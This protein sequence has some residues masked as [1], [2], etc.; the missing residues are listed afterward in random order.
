MF[1]KLFTRPGII[2]RYRAAP[3]YTERLRYLVHCAQ[4]GA[5]QRTLRVIAAHQANVVHF[6]DLRQGERVSQTRIEAAAARWSLPGERRCSQPARAD[7]SQRFLGHTVRWLRFADMLEEPDATGLA[8]VGELAA[9][10]AWMCKERGWSEDTVLGCCRTVNCFFEWL[11]EWGVAL[12]SVKIADIDRAIA[13]WHGRNCSRVTIHDYA[14]RLRTFFRFAEHRGWCVA[15]L[16]DGIMPSRFHPG[17]T[18]PK[19]LTRHEVMRLLATTESARPVDVRDRAI[20]MLLTVY[21]LRSGEVAGLRLDDLDWEE[22]TL[23]VRC[24]KPGRTHCY[25]LSRGVAQAIVRYISDVRPSR[26]DRVLFMT[27]NAPIRPL[28]GSAMFHVVR[29][30]LARLGIVGKRRGPHALRHAAAQHLLDQGLSMKEV[31]DYLGHR[32]VSATSAYAKVQLGAL[33][34][35]AAIDLEDLT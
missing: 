2:A 8:S 16:A 12:A 20:L 1:E 9:F 34:E 31:G 32:S 26:P 5:T 18:V 33:R 35:V 7:A 14:Q 22:E 30:R 4:G 19:G 28:S 6:L 11:H 27:L 29:S 17:E 24:P 21:G 10:A 15:G 23:R 25:P 13:R 3:L